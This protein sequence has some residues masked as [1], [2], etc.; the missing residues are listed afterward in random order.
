MLAIALKTRPDYACIVPEKRSEITT[1]GGIDV[2]KNKKHLAK[3]VNELQAKNIKVSL[4][5]DPEE[6]QAKASEESGATIVELHTGS[7]CNAGGTAQ[8]KELERIKKAAE[9][10]AELDIEC[11]AGHGLTFE[12]VGLIAAIPNIVELN[13]G[14]FLIGEAIF[15]GLKESIRQMRARIDEAREI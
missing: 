5:I 1:E 14:H 7:Y 2:V 9:I 10:C 6:A 11:H 3:F 8:K 4:F 15:I 13:I 12:N